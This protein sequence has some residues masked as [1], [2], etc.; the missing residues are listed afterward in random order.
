MIRQSSAD[1]DGNESGAELEPARD[2][3]LDNHPHEEAL[4][5][6]HSDDRKVHTKEYAEG[7]NK[8]IEVIGT[9]DLLTEAVEEVGEDL[10]EGRHYVYEFFDL[11]QLYQPLETESGSL[12]CKICLELGETVEFES[13]AAYTHHR[14]KVHGSYNIDHKLPLEMHFRTFSNILEFERF[15]HLIEVLSNCRFM[16][17]TKQPHNRRQIMHCSRSEHKIILQSKK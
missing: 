12:L 9:D 5:A 13:R 11:L 7:P 1:D 10:D 17:H 16:M 3:S 15:R 8:M 4:F 2:S 6:H 14:Y